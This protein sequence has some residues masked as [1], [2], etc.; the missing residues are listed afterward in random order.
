[1]SKQNYGLKLE[2]ITEDA[3][4]F[5]M[6]LDCGRGVVYSLVDDS[7][8][9]IGYGVSSHDGG[10]KLLNC[11]EIRQADLEEFWVHIDKQAKYGSER[12]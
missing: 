11:D 4:L 2:Q 8:N 9:P 1:M 6:P 12:V 10:A 7:P 3:P 5:F